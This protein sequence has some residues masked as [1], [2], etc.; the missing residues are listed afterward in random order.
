VQF[1]VSGGFYAPDG[2]MR[3]R[4]SNRNVP[5]ADAARYLKTI[6]TDR[7]R[8]GTAAP[9]AGVRAYV[10]VIL[11][12]DPMDDDKEKI[13]GRNAREFVGLPKA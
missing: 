9:G 8:F 11:S 2:P 6:G 7:C 13:L 4:D 3:A 10:R 12:F 5:L 1:D